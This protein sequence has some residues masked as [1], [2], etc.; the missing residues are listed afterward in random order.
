[1]ENQ[2]DKHMRDTQPIPLRRGQPGPA[3][4]PPSLNE[5]PARQETVE[6][7]AFRRASAATATDQDRIPTPVPLEA[8]RNNL[9]PARPRT[10]WLLRAIVAFCLLVSLASLALNIILIQNLVGVQQTFSDGIDEAIAALDNASGEVFEYEYRFQ[11]TIPFESD[12]PFQQDLVIPFKGNIPI[13]TT[14]QVPINA[15]PL[16]QFVIDVPIDTE[17]Y[18]DIEVPVSVDQTFHV[19]TEVPIDM[20]F[21]ISISADDPAIQKLLTGVREWLVE[22]RAS[23]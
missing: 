5:E 6:V 11:Q 18:V 16:G 17:F 12:I 2:E 23:F 7:P 1:M 8:P 4:T 13:N 19:A 21:P 15:G 14:V 10:S 3:E 22:L 20:T 9:S